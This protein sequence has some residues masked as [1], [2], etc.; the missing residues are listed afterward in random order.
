MLRE[1]L[2]PFI[3]GLY[4]KIGTRISTNYKAVIFVFILN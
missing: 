1:N 3:K 4:S 2:D